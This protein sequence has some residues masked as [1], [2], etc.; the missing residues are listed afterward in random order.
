MASTDK[1]YDLVRIILHD[2]STRR[3][4]YKLNYNSI[5]NIV[6]YLDNQ[7]ICHLVLTLQKISGL[8]LVP[9]TVTRL[10]IYY[11]DC[12]ANLNIEMSIGLT[13]CKFILTRAGAKKRRRD[14]KKRR[15]V[16]KEKLNISPESI[17]NMEIDVDIIKRVDGNLRRGAIER[18]HHEKRKRHKN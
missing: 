2:K 18:K 9:P 11:H 1:L 17:F 10:F 12:A 5:Q 6:C 7:M 3:I 15:A 4:I 14:T 16:T 8:L 13:M